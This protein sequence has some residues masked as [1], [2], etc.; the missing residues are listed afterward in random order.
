MLRRFHAFFG[1]TQQKTASGLLGNIY[2]VGPAILWAPAFL[3]THWIIR[4]DGFTLPYQVSLGVAGVFFTIIGLLLLYRL[5]LQ[6]FS[7]RIAVLTVCA[8]AFTTN[9]W[10]YGSLDT[11]N[12]HGLSFFAASLF[13]TL[14]FQKK[15]QFFFLGA[16]IGL[17]ALIRIQDAVFGLLLL[18]HLNR[19]TTIP[20]ALGFLLMFL[21]QMLA[22]QALYRKFWISPYLNL[23]GYGFNFFRPHIL[24][25]LFSVHNGLVT[26]TPIIGLAFVGLFFNNTIGK[27]YKFL[28]IALVTLQILL[29]ASWST[30]WQG[31]S[32]SGRMFISLLPIFAFGLAG[33][34]RWL[35][36]YHWTVQ[37]FLICIIVPLSIINFLLVIFFLLHKQT[38]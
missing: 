1:A 8:I 38:I 27:N 23:H 10:F 33:V 12:S 15:K 29:V 26:W 28:F 24:D 31:A 36:K 5:L 25:V 11:V 2:A 21:P 20:I 9:L 6:F 32:Y 4:G 22:W 37:Y 19:K 35:Q 7:E 18:P 14:F 16:A 13:L 17:L 34:F 30:W 3:W